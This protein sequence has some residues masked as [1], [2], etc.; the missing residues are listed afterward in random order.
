MNSRIRH[1]YAECTVACLIITRVSKPVLK[2]FINDFHPLKPLLFCV[3]FQDVVAGLVYV[4]ALMPLVLPLMDFIDKFI[5][6]Y[7]FSPVVIIS[8]PLLLCIY[9]PKLNHWSTARGDTTVILSVATGVCLGTR[10]AYQMGLMKRVPVPPPYNVIYP[11]LDWLW[12]MVLRMLVGV[13]MVVI[14]RQI[15]KPLSFRAAC[16]FTRRDTKEKDV[17][18]HLSIELPYKFI[19][20]TAVAFVAVCIVPLLF[21]QFGIERVTYFTEL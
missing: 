1:A 21:K 4:F 13:A 14:T 7:P 6:D 9:Y 11:D 15:V 12:K 19:T 8:I 3:R 10:L 2:P 5:L 17:F 20:Y 18:K 16:Y